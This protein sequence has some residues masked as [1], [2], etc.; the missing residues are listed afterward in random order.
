MLQLVLLIKGFIYSV[1]VGLQCCSLNLKHYQNSQ[2]GVVQLH[3]TTKLDY[4]ELEY[5]ISFDTHLRTRK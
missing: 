1:Y 4:G 2:F 3:F 5:K